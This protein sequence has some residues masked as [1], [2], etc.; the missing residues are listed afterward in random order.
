[1]HR[2]FILNKLE[3]DISVIIIGTESILLN[4]ASFLSEKKLPGKKFL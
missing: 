1:M 3:V 4:L 2:T